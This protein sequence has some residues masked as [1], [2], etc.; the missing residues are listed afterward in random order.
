MRPIAPLDDPLSRGEVVF[1]CL[2]VGALLGAMCGAC[3]LIVR[4]WG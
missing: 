1:L 2:C 3:W 4:A